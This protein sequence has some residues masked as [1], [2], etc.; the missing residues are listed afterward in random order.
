MDSLEILGELDELN[1]FLGFAKSFT[2]DCKFI[3][4]ISGIQDDIFLMQA[5]I[6]C[7]V[8]VIRRPRKIQEKDIL[9]IQQK[10]VNFETR[11]P[12]LQTFV[13]PEGDS[14]VC[15]L[16]VARTIARRVER[17]VIN[18]PVKL[19][20]FIATYLDRLAG[21]LFAMARFVNQQNG[22]SERSPQ[23][24]KKQGGFQE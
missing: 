5:E 19:N 6:G 3:N 8:E 17:K 23:Y 13:V 22:F 4:L 10:T 1:C 11:V 15:S 24:S 7:P 9:R 12:P 16:Q 18:N 2:A 20:S 14:F 21:L